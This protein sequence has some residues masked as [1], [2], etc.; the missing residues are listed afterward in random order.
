LS[1][2]IGLPEDPGQAGKSQISYLSGRLAGYRIMAFR[3]TGSKLTRALPVASQVEANNF[4]IVRGSWNYTLLSEMADF[5]TGNKDDQVD[6]LVR[7]FMTLV[8]MTSQVRAAS[9]PYLAR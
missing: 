6:A 3:E 5:P 1:V 9:L 8:R 7:G 4:S 2:W